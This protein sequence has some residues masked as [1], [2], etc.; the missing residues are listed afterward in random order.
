MSVNVQ[1]LGQSCFAVEL[2][3]KTLVID[4][5]ISP[6]PKATEAG[7]SPEAVKADAI[8]V[9]HGHQDHVAALKT[10]YDANTS[11][12]VVSNFE[13]CQWAAKQGMDNILPMNHGGTV[14]LFDNEVSITYVNAVHSSSFPDGTYAGN[15]GGFIIKTPEVCF[16]HSG[17]TALMAD[18]A[19][20]GEY[21]DFDF[22]M[23]C[24]GG[25]FT[26]DAAEAL[27]A[28]DLLRCETVIGMHYDT[29]PPIEIDH[30][31][32]HKMFKAAGKTLHLMPIAG[33]LDI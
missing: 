14:T 15:P 29:F 12:T 9:T 4:P 28:S 23:L 30:D 27:K 13:I 26:M 17:D 32:T 2:D 11:P 10:V 6:N 24:L 20:W 25:V 31:R 21:Y 22:V 5:F 16:Y 33:K 7:L 1:Y 8:L 18:M 3:K 19:L